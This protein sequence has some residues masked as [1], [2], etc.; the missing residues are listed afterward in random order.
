MIKIEKAVNGSIVSSL[1]LYILDNDD[2]KHNNRPFALIENVHTIEGFENKGYASQLLHE[3]IDIARI[4]NCYKVILETSS[5]SEVV[6]HL[7]AKAGFT[8]GYKTAYYLS[9][10]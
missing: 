2:P 1:N 5:K 9:L 4:K 3:A 6:E 10:E 8:A 7:Y